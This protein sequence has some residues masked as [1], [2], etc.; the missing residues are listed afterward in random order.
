MFLE[1]SFHLSSKKLMGILT[2]Y[3]VRHNIRKADAHE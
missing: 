3:E 2:E 1:I